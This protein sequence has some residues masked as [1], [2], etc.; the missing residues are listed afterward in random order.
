ML[1]CWKA[2]RSERP[3]FAKITRVI[4]KWITSPETI[5]DKVNLEQLPDER[6]ALINQ[7]P[8]FED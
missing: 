4:D 5:N 3:S 6:S 2:E 7:A 1:Q 8:N